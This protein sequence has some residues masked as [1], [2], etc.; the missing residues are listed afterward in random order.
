M[1][2]LF[3]LV[4]YSAVSLLVKGQTPYTSKDIGVWVGES[5]YLGELNQK[6]FA[7]FNLGLGAFY[8]YNY[9]DRLSAR[10]GF[11][12]GKIS[13]N[14]QL[15]GSSFDNQR[16]FSFSSTIM[17]I[18]AIGEFNFLPFSH[19]NPKSAL[20][21]PYFFF[22]LSYFH[23][24]PKGNTGGENVN[25]L[26]GNSEGVRYRNLQLGIPMG[27]G[28][29]VMMGKMGM[30]FQWGIRKT[31]TDYLDQVSAY[32]HTGSDGENFQRG[33]VFTKDWFVFTG[34]CLFLNLTPARSCPSP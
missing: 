2:K 33:Q 3:L 10:F 14:D 22:G 16:N 21:T 25:F 17:E 27:V 28:M 13:G 20:S 6:H 31:F 12:Y 26:T 9:D 5:Y 4:I 8:R 7:P 30:E 34:L 11:S 1:K 32:N 15:S 19:L 18:S 24:Q 29:K 23:H